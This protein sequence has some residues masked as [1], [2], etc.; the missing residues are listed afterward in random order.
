[1]KRKASGPE[2]GGERDANTLVLGI[3]FDAS[4]LHGLRVED[5]AVVL[6]RDGADFS[7]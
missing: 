4:G 3:F 2:R 5:H 7:E 1:L 6:Y